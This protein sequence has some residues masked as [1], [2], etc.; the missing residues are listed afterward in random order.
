MHHWLYRLLAV[1]L[2]STLAACG[3]GQ[4]NAPATPAAV[5]A[6]VAPR[7]TTAQLEQAVT[8]T[9]EEADAAAT[10]IE[11]VPLYPG[12]IPPA[13]GSELAAIVDGMKQQLVQG[14]GT[15]QG[16]VSVEG[17]VLPAN[18]TFEDVMTFYEEE[19]P[20]RGWRLEPMSSAMTSASG[21][22]AT[23]SSTTG[24]EGVSI[25]AMD[26]PTGGERDIF[27]IIQGTTP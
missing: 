2:L 13:S 18:V 4:A 21:S 12:A 8:A 7:A 9:T 20:A 24:Q 3:A 14:P 17:Y 15:D 19:L 23:W 25:M 6:T 26:D 22:T 5:Q 10:G 16:T 11:A 1:L 27:F